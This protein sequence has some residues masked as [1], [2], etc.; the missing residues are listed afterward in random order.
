MSLRRAPDA[1]LLLVVGDDAPPGEAGDASE[2]RI[3]RALVTQLNGE[4]ALTRDGGT[5][6]TATLPDTD[7]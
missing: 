6:A 3:V 7:A 4:L 1:K 5:V 2:S